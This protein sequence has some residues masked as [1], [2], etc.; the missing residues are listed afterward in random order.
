MDHN[1]DSFIGQYGYIGII[2]ALAGGIIGLPIPDELLLTFIG[3][4][5]SQGRLTYVM[6]LGSSFVGSITGITISYFIGLKLG[7]PFLKKFGPIMYITEERIEFTRRMFQRWGVLMIFFGYFIPGVRQITAII[8]AISHISFR[9][10]V[11][12]AYTGGL[13]W[14]ILFISLGQLLGKSWIKAVQYIDDFMLYAIGLFILVGLI[15]FTTRLILYRSEKA[16][17]R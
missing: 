13:V 2:L 3:Y 15:A 14:S 11:L 5:V 4:S 7:L 17:A 12:Y 8:A 6:A 1:L 16:K 9:K 10:F